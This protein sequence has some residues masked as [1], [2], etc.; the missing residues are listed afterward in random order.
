M[1]FKRHDLAILREL[2]ITDFKLRYQGSSLG[3]LWSLMRP[4]TLFTIYY[5]VFTKFLRFGDSMEHYT[6]YLLSGIMLWSFFSEATVVGMQSIVSRAG[7][8]RKLNIN[9]SVIVISTIVS[10]LINLLINLLV[11]GLF[12]WLTGGTYF[13]G[14]SVILVPVYLAGLVILTVAVA[15]ILA[16]GY[17]YYR[18]IGHL[19]EVGLQAIFYLTP[20]IYP[21]SIIPEH[22][23]KVIMLS[24][25][26]CFVQ[27]IRELTITDQVITS[28]QVGGWTYLGIIGLLMVAI[29]GF[30]WMIFAKQSKKFA[31]NI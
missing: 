8:I 14:I 11:L 15:F 25:L 3:Y 27:G 18:D 12:L 13:A 16:T 31:E 19:W 10:A 2:V 5:L 7:L 22:F 21:V 4:L 30:A 29:I 20:F 24:P 23:R 9:K 6:T 28:Y 1:A 17:V 26:A